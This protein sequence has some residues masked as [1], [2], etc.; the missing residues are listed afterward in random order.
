MKRYLLSRVRGGRTNYPMPEVRGS[1]REE[2]PHIK[3]AA[4]ARA[5]EGQEKLLHLQGQEGQP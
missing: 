2:Q 1:G 3:G 5:Q 4:A